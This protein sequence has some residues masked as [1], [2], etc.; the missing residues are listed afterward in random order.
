MDAAELF[1]K[2]ETWKQIKVDIP[3]S[4]RAEAKGILAELLSKDENIILLKEKL[5][6]KLSI[7]R[8]LRMML[9]KQCVDLL[10]DKIPGLDDHLLVSDQRKAHLM[11]LVEIIARSEKRDSPVKWESVSL[12]L[13]LNVRGA[14][15]VFYEMM[16][17]IELKD[18]P[19]VYEK[20]IFPGVNPD[21][22]LP[23]LLDLIL[24]G[25]EYD[26]LWLYKCINWVI[27][28]VCGQVTVDSLTITR[29][30]GYFRQKPTSDARL[31]SLYMLLAK[32]VDGNHSPFLKEYANTLWESWGQS[33]TGEMWMTEF[34]ILGDVLNKPTI[35]TE[36]GNQLQQSIKGGQSLQTQNNGNDNA[37]TVPFLTGE[38]VSIQNHPSVGQTIGQ[39]KNPSQTEENPS[40]GGGKQQRPVVKSHF[41]NINRDG[42]S[43]GGLR[44]NDRYTVKTLRSLIGSLI[45]E[46][47]QVE[48]QL[49]RGDELDREVKALHTKL[50][51]GQI[52]SD[53]MVRNLAETRK[54][55]FTLEK[56]NIE[57][58][59]SIQELYEVKER[60]EKD[61]R[62]ALME[63]ESAVANFRQRLWGLLEPNL[64]EAMNESITPD[65]MPVNE[66][67]LLVKLRQILEVLKDEQV[68]S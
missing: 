63:G 52:I 35:V 66:Q 10:A 18:L 45:R 8:A 23:Y 3:K 53:E 29:L 61:V 14:L 39:E 33:G 26:T 54:R 57:K 59:K 38:P 21:G 65:D 1:E 11:E 67:I 42:T 40:F 30:E 16:A 4:Q 62:L 9:V 41:N 13:K 12:L 44:S 43:T 17:D 58:D 32:V 49:L 19:M 48:E 7:Q 60:R 64:F 15:R 68:T 55:I 25:R 27:E 28:R 56:E 20:K 6:Y 46:I 2:L 50:R 34:R 5:K 22:G 36:S 37:L 24:E 31:K 51:D 47:S